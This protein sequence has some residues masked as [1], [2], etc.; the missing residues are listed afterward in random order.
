V[1][2]SETHT[3]ARTPACSR[4][5]H[6]AP[7]P[8]TPFVRG[9]D[10]VASLQHVG[11][12][13]GHERQQ[14]V[15][16]LAHPLCSELA[17]LRCRA[18][19]AVQ[20]QQLIGNGVEE[21]VAVRRY[22]LDDQRLTRQLLLQDAELVRAAIKHRA[23]LLVGLALLLAFALLLALLHRGVAWREVSE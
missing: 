23:G 20:Q 6:V 4:A 18:P 17:E 22:L 14:L 2:V 9:L 10:L 5:R 3:Q 7:Y 8:I 16:V 11:L 13:L 15:G 19:L 12:T 21:A 1:S